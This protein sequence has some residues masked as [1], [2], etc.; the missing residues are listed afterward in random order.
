[1]SLASEIRQLATVDPRQAIRE[2]RRPF[3]FSNGTQSGLVYHADTQ[4]K[5]PVTQ[6][7]LDARMRMS[8]QETTSVDRLLELALH[9]VR[10]EKGGTSTSD[11]RLTTAANI[12]RNLAW[13]GGA[14]LAG[15]VT[16]ADKL[17]Q[18]EHIIL[19]REAAAGAVKN[20]A[21]Y[22]GL[23]TPLT[24]EVATTEYPGASIRMLFDQTR[25]VQYVAKYSEELVRTDRVYAFLSR[26]LQDGNRPTS[27]AAAEIMA[28]IF[29][30]S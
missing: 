28:E 27:S 7:A 5:W 12:L 10:T 2:T 19:A 17:M 29:G 23:H 18:P 3:R 9:L 4:G 16:C 21:W 14:H 1:M 25:G 26:R 15:V 13:Q 20:A 24:I 22:P 6:A 11:L 8:E 30:K